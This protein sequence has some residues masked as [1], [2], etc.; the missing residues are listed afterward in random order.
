VTLINVNSEN[1]SKVIGK[2][3][4]KKWNHSA[5]ELFEGWV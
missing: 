4:K 2:K 3:K 1:D 5:Y